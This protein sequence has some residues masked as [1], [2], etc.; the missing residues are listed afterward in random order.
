MRC[1]D[2]VTEVNL[3]FTT[4]RLDLTNMFNH[5]LIMTGIS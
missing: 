3:F 1:E 4:W 5:N 2:V